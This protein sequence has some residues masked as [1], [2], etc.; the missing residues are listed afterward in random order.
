[1][2]NNTHTLALILVMALVTA[3]LKFLPFM[4]LGKR[5]TTP[6]FILYL[7]KV[8]PYAVMGMLVVYCLRSIHFTPVSSFLPNLLAVGLTAILQVWKHN[9]LIS[10]IGGTACYMVLV[11]IIFA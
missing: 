2:T 4:I 8:L 7:G 1:M 10:I 6:D 3:A 9:T 5:K 11:Q